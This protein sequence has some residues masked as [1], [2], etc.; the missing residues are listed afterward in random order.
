MTTSAEPISQRPFRI[1]D[2]MVL[3]AALFVALAW[4]RAAVLRTLAEVLYRLKSLFHLSFSFWGFAFDTAAVVLLLIPFLVVGSL[5]V[6]ALRLQRPRP[7]LR[8][9]LQQPGAVACALAT[10]AIV[11][12]GIMVLVTH[13]F[14]G[15]PLA[16]AWA[17]AVDDLKPES[18]T[19]V[20]ALI[21]F[22]V[23]VAWIV[24]R[25]KRQWRPE[26]SWIDGFGRLLG[27]G[28]IAMIFG[29]M[30]QLILNLVRLSGM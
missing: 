30:I 24:M 12:A 4:D 21:G 29:G 5:S 25:S 8:Q 6:L 9:L 10:L 22:A 19:V 14:S 23:L 13:F 28:W 11:P 15:R 7:G 26:A 16:Y 18:L 3:I 17:R 2:A 27:W 1:A 20:A